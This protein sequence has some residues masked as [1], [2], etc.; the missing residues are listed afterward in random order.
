MKAA[1]LF[2]IVLAS[3]CFSVSFGPSVVRVERDWTVVSPGAY[4]FEGSL[5][6]ND[7]NQKVLS[8]ETDPPMAVFT[9][10]QGNIRVQYN[11]TASALK[12]VAIIAVDFNTNITEDPAFVKGEPLNATNLTMWNAGIAASADNLTANTTLE[13]IRNI[14]NFVH[15]YI[16]YNISY[17]GLVLNATE[18][19]A[20]R[21]GVCVEY[22][23]LTISM[24]RYLGMDTRFVSGFVNGGQWQA[25]A[26]AEVYV[27]GY[28]WLP[29][30]ST[31][32]EIGVLDDS[33]VAEAK[34]RDQDDIFDLVRSMEPGNGTIQFNTS[35]TAEFINE[36]QDLQGLG[37][38]YAFDGPAGVLNVT[39]ENGRND[40]VFGTYQAILS[41]AGGVNESTIV[42]L[43]PHEDLTRSYSLDYSALRPG[44]QYTMPFLATLDDAMA[45]GNLSLNV[46]G[47]ASC[48]NCGTNQQA[49]SCLP[50][51]ILLGL[52]VLY[53][54]RQ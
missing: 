5:A 11:G 45:S 8:I 53:P 42:L 14:A 3:C 25:H 20:L 29:V 15:G 43:T 47:T 35:G 26:W 1:V 12:A 9:D 40:Y 22:S 32:G 17:F 28:G 16:D 46:T 41:G 10:P 7:S 44:Y 27:P 51:Y 4:Y 18:T 31:F 21:Q 48:T 49:P 38:S 36:S 34:G 2:V 54:S 23:H 33:H 37:L 6:L 13:T 50:A 39:L 52:L 19:Y 30:D 24:A